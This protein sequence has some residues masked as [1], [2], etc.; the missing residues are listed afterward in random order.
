MPVPLKV[1]SGQDWTMIPTR[2]FS[3]LLLFAFSLTPAVRPVVS[4]VVAGEKK[5]LFKIRF[6]RKVNTLIAGYDKTGELS[7]VV[8][9]LDLPTLELY[10]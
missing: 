5:K 6:I 10:P 8:G 7:I 9:L 4:E 2:D 3:C 1:D